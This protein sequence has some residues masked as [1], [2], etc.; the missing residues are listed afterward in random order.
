MSEED[1]EVGRQ[2][3]GLAR[4]GFNVKKVKEI[5]K[6]RNKKVSE[7]LIEALELYDIVD[8]FEDVD[9]RCLAVGLKLA[10]HLMM[11]TTRLLVESS[12]VYS[13]EMV[14]HVVQSYAAA[15]N[16]YAQQQSMQQ[17]QAASAV[18]NPMAA[19]MAPLMT[20]LMSMITNLITSLT[21]Q[22]PKSTQ[23]STAPKIKILE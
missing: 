3:G 16:Q 19:L 23:I 2:L 20:Q 7:V 10:E 6:R 5:A 15:L 12:K 13:T 21:S 8:T 17:A 14:Q 4:A 9:P 22:M 11:Y 18:Q 1:M